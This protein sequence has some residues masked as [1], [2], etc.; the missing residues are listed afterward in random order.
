[1]MPWWRQ[2]HVLADILCGVLTLGFAI[3]SVVKLRPAAASE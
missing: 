2:A 1:M 3:W